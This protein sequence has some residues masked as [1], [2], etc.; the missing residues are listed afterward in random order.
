MEYKTV[1]EARKRLGWLIPPSNHEP[2]LI[3]RYA[4]PVAVIVPVDWLSLSDAD[5]LAG[6]AKVRDALAEGPGLADQGAASAGVR[7]S[8][9]N[10]GPGRPS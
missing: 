2:V 6:M 7:G 3:T 9:N 4:M 5:L 10:S 8:G 1:E